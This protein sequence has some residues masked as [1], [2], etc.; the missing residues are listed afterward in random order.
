MSEDPFISLV[1]AAGESYFSPSYLWRNEGRGGSLCWVLQRTLQGRAYLSDPEGNRQNVMEGQAMLFHHDDG[2]S[3]GYPEDFEGE[4]RLEYMAFRGPLAETFCRKFGDGSACVLTLSPRGETAS[5]FSGILE[6]FRSRGFRDSWHC[7]EMVYRLLVALWREQSG[8][9]RELDPLE[10]CRIRIENGHA[11]PISVKGLADEI[12]L[13]R[14]HL[15]RGFSERFGEPPGRMLRRLRLDRAKA[16]LASSTLDIEGTALAC[17]YAAG[18]SFCRAFKEAFGV[19]P[20]AFRRSQG[21]N[22]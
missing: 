19:S 9:Q 1:T 11:S 4:Y 14:E 16:I 6:L 17:G 12:G 18:H 5:I 2:C 21:N 15:A 13:S 10:Y 20:R 22:I 7:S 3:Y 8:L